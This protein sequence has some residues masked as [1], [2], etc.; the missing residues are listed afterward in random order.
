MR[1]VG[2]AVKAAGTRKGDGDPKEPVLV[3]NAQPATETRRPTSPSY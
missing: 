1:K 3:W 2:G